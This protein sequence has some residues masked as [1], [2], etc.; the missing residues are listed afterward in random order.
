VARFEDIDAMHE[1]AVYARWPQVDDIERPAWW[2]ALIVL[3]YTT[4]FR[5]TALLALTWSDVDIAERTIT[6]PARFDKCRTERRKPLAPEA[7]KALLRCRSPKHEQLL[8][9][10]HSE[11]TFYREW[12]QLQELAGIPKAR[13]F[14]LHDL[15]RTAGTKLAQQ[16]NPWAVQMMLDHASIQTSR[17]YVNAADSLRPALERLP[18]PG[19]FAISRERTEN[20]RS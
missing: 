4:A 18:M 8:P 1:A 19:A 12:R 20:V 11:Q 2:R 10:P 17:H 14:T 15:K 13:R 9:W 7:L 16:G 6:L 3:A 5:K